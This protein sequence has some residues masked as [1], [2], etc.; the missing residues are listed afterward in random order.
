M[1]DILKKLGARIREERKNARLT[2]EKLAE[3]VDLSVDYIGYIERGKQAPYLKT[4]E[5]IATALRVEVYK[6]FLFNETE[7]KNQQDEEAAI[8]ELLLVLRNK[9]P[10]DIRF[11]ASILKQI[12]VRIES[13]RKEG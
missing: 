7:K 1:K 4:L 11:A 10:E 9:K 12:L 8:K 13:P 3:R 5:R 6:L 2:Q